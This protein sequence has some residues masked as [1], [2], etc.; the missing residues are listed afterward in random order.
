MKKT[1]LADIASYLGV[2]KTLV[3]MVLNNKGDEHA[4]SKDTQ[5]RVKEAAKSLNYQPN[6]IA[7]SLRIGKSKTIGLI[8]ADISNPF[9]AKISRLIEDNSSRLGYNLIIC[10]TDE[11]SDKERKL[12]DMLKNRQVDGIIL[13][14]TLKNSNEI[15]DILFD[16][17][18]LVLIDRTFPDMQTNTVIV[19]NYLGARKATEHLVEQGFESIAHFTISPSYVSCIVDRKNGYLHVMK[20]Q[21]LQKYSQVIEIPFND[22][23]NSVYNFIKEQTQKEKSIDAIFTV[24]NNI[25]LAVFEAANSL[26]L[27]IPEDIGL[28]TFDDIDLFNFTNPTISA[29]KQPIELICEKAVQTLIDCI[30][31]TVTKTINH[32][33]ESEIIVRQSSI[34]K[35]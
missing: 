6:Q 28:I 10:S 23:R 22:V 16:N 12:L 13:S 27:R 26:K 30:E 18:P 19:D 14:S 1:S 11:N 29:I 24:N 7:R 25:A 9:Y 20:E 21:K 8:V 31:N 2:S 32:V 15:R 5:K 3:S 34:L 4:I 33:L 17:Y 35:K